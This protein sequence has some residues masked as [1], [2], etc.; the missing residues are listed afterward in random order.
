MGE[1]SVGELESERSRKLFTPNP[2]THITD[3]ETE[4]LSKVGG[5]GGSAPG[6]GLLTFPNDPSVADT[7]NGGQ[8]GLSLSPRVT[9]LF[10]KDQTA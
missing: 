4:D 2:S 9:N 6:P 5:G 10:N 1:A 3:D 7:D 8:S